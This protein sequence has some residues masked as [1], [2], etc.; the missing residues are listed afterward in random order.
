ML[1]TWVGTRSNRYYQGILLLQSPWYYYSSLHPGIKVEFMNIMNAK[2]CDGGG[3][4]T[5]QRSSEA[6]PR[7]FIRPLCP[8][9]SNICMDMVL[10]GSCKP[11]F[12]FSMVYLLCCNTLPWAVT[13][14][15]CI[16]RPGNPFIFTL[17]HPHFPYHAVEHVIENG[18]R[19]L[20]LE[21]EQGPISKTSSL[22]NR[23]QTLI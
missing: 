7:P 4:R 14:D 3:R 18:I 15:C 16:D 10:D 8:T 20:W 22:I 1:L 12:V 6:R 21:F 2:Q 5:G 19:Y 23:R 17:P 9:I 11:T 13:S